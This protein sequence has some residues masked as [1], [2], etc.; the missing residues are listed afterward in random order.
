[1]PARGFALVMVLAVLVVVMLIG[2]SLASSATDAERVARGER[3]R[4]LA[5]QMA[6]AALH[7]AEQ[8]LA[9]ADPD[10]AVLSEADWRTLDL[11]S[12]GR[13]ASE[14]VA[15]QTGAGP[16]PAQPPRYVLERLP[17]RLPGSD[18][19]QAP[20]WVYRVTAIGFGARPDTYAVVQSM[21]RRPEAP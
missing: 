10:P 6:E 3:E 19:E 14:A 8:A 17:V 21:Y 11:R 15:G 2:A 4:A 13:P 12:A 18:A 5:F 20:L 9:L 1:M 16:M 7:E